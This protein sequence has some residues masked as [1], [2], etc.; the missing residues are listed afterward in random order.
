M[1]LFLS[2][3]NVQCVLE[4]LSFKDGCRAGIKPGFKL[5]EEKINFRL[6]GKNT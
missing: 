2:E 1:K 6:S 4:H 5:C 3:A